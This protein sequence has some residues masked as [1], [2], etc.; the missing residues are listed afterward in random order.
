M[1][2]NTRATYWP[3][4][5]RIIVSFVLHMSGV[6]HTGRFAN[7]NVLTAD[8]ISGNSPTAATAEVSEN[9]SEPRGGAQLREESEGW[10]GK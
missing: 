10:R 8:L 1:R 4:C 2:P 5:P 6:T 3:C 7:A 9:E